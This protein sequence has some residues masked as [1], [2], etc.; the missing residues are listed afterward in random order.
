MPYNFGLLTK[1]GA[2]TD[3]VDE[4]QSLTIDAGGGTYTLT[5]GGQTTAAIAF[6]AT[7]AQVQAALRALSTIGSSGVTVTGAAGGPYT[8][9][10]GGP[11]SGLPQAE[12][13]TDDTNLTGGAGTAVVAEVTT[14]VRGDYRGAPVKQPLIDTTNRKIFENTGTAAR[15]VWGEVSVV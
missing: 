14:G 7:A 15:P 11:L 1:A 12:M 10:F 9:T 2:P 13:T 3:G 4:V 6:D 8:I 5:F